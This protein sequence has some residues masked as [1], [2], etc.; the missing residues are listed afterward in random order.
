MNNEW[1]DI[2]KATIWSEKEQFK[3]KEPNTKSLI[4][5][6]AYYLTVNGMT[7]DHEI[8]YL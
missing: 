5:I 1:I 3:R 6:R 8:G 7:R 2:I 4:S